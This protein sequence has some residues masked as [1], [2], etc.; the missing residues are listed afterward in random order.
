MATATFDWYGPALLKIA[1]GTL[2]LGSGTFKVM[3]AESTYTPDPDTH[4]F[5]DDV[6]PEEVGTNWASGGQTVTLTLDHHAA[7]NRIRVFLSDISVSDVT[8]VDGKTAVLYK[9]L[10]GAASADPIIAYGTFDVALAPSAGPVTIDFDAT[11]GVL[12]WEY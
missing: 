5:R 8:F 4:D 11:N 2:S 7:S 6:T 3:L 9:A 1:N 10:G 12:Y